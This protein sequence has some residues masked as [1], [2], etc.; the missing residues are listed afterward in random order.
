MKALNIVCR[1]PLVLIAAW[2]ILAVCGAQ[3]IPPV[4][5][6]PL[7]DSITQGCYIDTQGGYRTELYT[8]LSNAGF[9]VDFVGT[10]VDTDLAVPDPDHEGHPGY[11]IEDL[12]NGLPLWTKQV[13]DPDVILLHVGTVDFWLGI[14]LAA[15][16]D[17]LKNLLADLSALRPHAK[18]IV[19]SLIPRDDEYDTIQESYNSSLP[20]IVSEQVALGRQV[21]FV[22]LHGVLGSPNQL[23]PEDFIADGV[24]PQLSGY[25][26]MAA[27]WLPGI[28]SVITP[29]GI[30][31]PPAIARVDA[32]TD[33]QHVTVTF[34]K[35][36]RDEDVISANFLLSGGLIISAMNLDAVSKRIVTL[37]TNAQ[38]PSTIYT[39]SVSGIHD[40]MPVANQIAPGSAMSF[41]SQTVIDWSFE[42]GGTAWTSSGNVAV[43]NS[44]IPPATD[45]HKLLMFHGAGTLPD[46]VISQSIPTTPGQKYRLQF[47]M[48]VY[49]FNATGVQGLQVT[50]TGNSVLLSQTETMSGLD[51][52]ATRWQVTSFEFVADSAITTL[53]FRDVS[54]VTYS[55]E[56]LLDDV[57]L[58]AVITWPLA[59]NSSPPGGV[60]VAAS[61]LDVDGNGSGATEFTRYYQD[62]ATVT[63]T[64][65]ANSGTFLFSEWQE[66]GMTHTTTP[67]VTVTMNTSRY[68]TAVYVKS[69]TPIALADAYSTDENTALTVPAPGVLANDS[70]PDSLPLTAV[71]DQEPAHGTLSLNADGGFGYTPNPDFSGTD[72][73]TYHASNGTASSGPVAASIVINPVGPFTNGGFELG[74]P[75]DFGS[76]D[77]WTVSGNPGN[78]P[79]GFTS[80]G[81]GIVP[82]YSP[83][84]G[85]RMAVFSSG[86]DDFSG[87]ISQTF[88][89]IPG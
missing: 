50:V 63:V 5:I 18:I 48:G 2:G 35:P 11:S 30:T 39:L 84:E 60:S 41:T 51:G 40:R 38:A 13:A 85:A 59:V 42:A 62:G 4:R 79:V 66:N 71:L 14:S 17:H 76:L 33:L 16:Q 83:S 86:S 21:Y 82:V 8:L 54:I 34:S 47:D 74:I 69:T 55:I 77:G 19:A 80:T 87:S 31:D 10:Q 67:V 32:Q 46:G 37:T 49:A 65:P 56:L 26:K 45:G 78:Q 15:T 68:L 23:L 24:H 43:T 44:S 57:R 9:N 1:L 70:E 29:N 36:I 28:T 25:I 64:A 27:Q 58:S 7:G 20:G 3:D 75:A 61:P 89:T 52:G 53:Q 12:R 22:D 81:P 6:M 88:S 72:S 73:F